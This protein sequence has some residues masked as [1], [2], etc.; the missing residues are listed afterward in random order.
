MLESRVREIERRGA[1][2]GW[3]Y[4]RFFEAL[5]EAG[6]LY[7]VRD[8]PRHVITYVGAAEQHQALPPVGF[9]D[10]KTADRFDAQAL[11]K[12]LARIHRRETTYPQFLAEIAAAGVLSYRV[13]MAKRTVTYMGGQG[14]TFVE[15]VPPA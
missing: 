5:K 6:V 4:P 8:V 15:R 12:A 13:D 7:Y 9:R 10:L 3:P 2:E 1:Q 11:K 14:E